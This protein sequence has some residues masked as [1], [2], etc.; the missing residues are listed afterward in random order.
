MTLHVQFVTLFTMIAGGFYLGL[1]KD[2]LQRFAPLWESRPFLVYGIEISFWL[3][4]TSFL[5]YLLYRVNAGELRLI[6]FIACL[7]GFSIYQALATTIYQRILEGVIR[8]LSTIFRSVA[9]TADL[10]FIRP[11]RALFRFIKLCIIRVLLVLRTIGYF[12]LRLLFFPIKWIWKGLYALI[13][14]KMLKKLPKRER[15]CS[16]MKNIS[17]TWHDLRSI[18][19]R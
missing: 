2:T 3:M 13:P 14:A 8:I 6:I 18:F 15:I 9:R 4:N 5:F 17:K 7:L 1:A 16:I 19:R 11:I 10:L 12:L